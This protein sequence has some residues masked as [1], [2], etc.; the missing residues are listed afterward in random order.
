[1]LSG[2]QAVQVVEMAA[3]HSCP[4]LIDV[5][6]GV[7]PTVRQGVELAIR[8]EVTAK[9]VRHLERRTHSSPIPTRFA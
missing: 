7:V 6:S 4:P 2:P 3:E 1:V 8:V 5:A 9:E